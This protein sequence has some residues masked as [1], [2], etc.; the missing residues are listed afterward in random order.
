[1]RGTV[2]LKVSYLQ[3]MISVSRL[4]MRLICWCDLYAKIYGTYF[5]FY[6]SVKAGDSDTGCMKHWFDWQVER[7]Y[8]STLCTKSFPSVRGRIVYW[9]F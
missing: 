8:Q 3:F 9:Y 5:A 7:V 4:R 1:M 6:T 2:I